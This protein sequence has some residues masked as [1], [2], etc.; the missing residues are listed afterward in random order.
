LLI[1]SKGVLFVEIFM[2]LGTPPIPADWTEPDS[3]PLCP[4]DSDRTLQNDT[5]SDI[6]VRQ[7]RMC[8]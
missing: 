8:Q 5:S 4:H 1:G 2:S 7:S 6:Q 3:W